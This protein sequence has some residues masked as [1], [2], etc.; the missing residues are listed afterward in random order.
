MQ[1]ISAVFWRLAISFWSGKI[2]ILFQ[3]LIFSIWHEK[4]LPGFSGRPSLL[5]YAISGYG[6][7]LQAYASPLQKSLIFPEGLWSVAS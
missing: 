2:K 7:L 4:G 1:I 3:G 6:N 5:I